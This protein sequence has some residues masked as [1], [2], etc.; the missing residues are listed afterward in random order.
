MVDASPNMTAY[1]STPPATEPDVELF[2]H[3]PRSKMYEVIRQPKAVV[4]HELRDRVPGWRVDAHAFA[5]APESVP[6]PP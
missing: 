2:G 5:V 1:A 6:L 4:D 3:Q